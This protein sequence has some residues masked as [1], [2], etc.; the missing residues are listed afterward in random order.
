MQV[1]T[2]VSELRAWRKA[3]YQQGKQVGFV[4][5]M[6]NLHEGHLQL[7]KAASAECDVVIASIFVNPMQFGQ[8]E[9]L[10]AYPRTIEADK[11]KLIAQGVDVLFLPAVDEM[12]PRGLNRQ[13]FVEVPGLSDII[14]GVTRPGH[15]RG[16]ATVVSKLFNMVVPDQ[17]FFG[18]KDFQQLQVIQTMVKDLSMDVVICPVAT[19]RE[20]DGLAM[21]SRNGYLNEKER[22]IAPF[23]F[24]TLKNIRAAVQAG[25]SNYRLVEKEAQ[26]ALDV[27]GFKTDYVTIRESETLREAQSGDTDLVVLIAAYL[28]TTRLIDNLRFKI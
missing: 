6:G 17:A 21:S 14:C 2:T 22:K 18:E 5:T 9:D 8:N 20:A 13:T 4:P 27:E 10:D 26:Q 11:T 25:Q 28:R 12:Y 15:F 1:I 24:Q 7:V 16:V 19:E 23:V 3:L